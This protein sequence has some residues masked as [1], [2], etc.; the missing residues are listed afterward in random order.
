MKA[1]RADVLSSLGIHQDMA[2]FNSYFYRGI[3]RIKDPKSTNEH[4]L[5]K[6]PIYVVE[7]TSD[8]EYQLI[9]VYK[10]VVSR[11]RRG[12]PVLDEYGQY[13]AY[14]DFE[15]KEVH[16]TKYSPRTELGRLASRMYAKPSKT[17]K[18]YKS[19]LF[20]A[21]LT[22]GVDTFTHKEGVGFNEY[23]EDIVSGTA[24]AKTELKP[25]GVF[26]CLSSVSWDKPKIRPKEVIEHIYRE[27][28]KKE[29]RLYNGNH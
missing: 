27:K 12:K 28:Q 29:G 19:P 20:I 17:V 16:D 25:T 22:Y 2:E 24:G 21:P 26:I 9:A 10:A 15:L 14:K 5:P 23:T 7:T 11:D 4:P 18:V 6:L 13:Y 1:S 8:E 3:L